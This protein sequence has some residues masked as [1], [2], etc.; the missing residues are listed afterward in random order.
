MHL[1]LGCKAC[2]TSLSSVDMAKIKSE[3]LVHYFHA[4]GTPLFNV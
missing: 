4:N 1:C 3:F 2:K